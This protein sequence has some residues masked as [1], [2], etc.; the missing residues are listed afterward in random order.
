MFLKCKIYLNTFILFT[1]VFS[2]YSYEGLLLPSQSSELTSI[3]SFE[4][5]KDFILDLNS[6]S[7]IKSSLLVLPNDIYINSFHYYF[8]LLKYSAIS[9]FTIINYGSFSDSETGNT[10]LSKDIIFKNKLRYQLKNNLYIA[11]TFKYMHSSIDS[12]K[13]SII[14]LDF[15]SYYHKNNLFFNAFLNNYGLILGSYT[16]YKENL[17]T[18][19]GAR[20]SYNLSNINLLMFCN[21]QI[22]SDYSEIS[23]NNKFFIKDKYF[24]SIGYTSL[25]KNLY[26][27]DFNNDFLV[28]FNLGVSIIYNNYIIDFGFKNLGSLGYINAISL[29]KLFN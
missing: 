3:N 15:S 1:L 22:F 23:F 8:N 29:S 26:S 18:S 6:S 13:S 25:A 5:D 20:I 7:R 17:P 4:I 19:Y 28:G 11:G 14:S 9:N 24:V 27:G 12:Y 21:Y 10:F 16:G 2:N